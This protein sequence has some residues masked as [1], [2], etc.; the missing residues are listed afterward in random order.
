MTSAGD[1]FKGK[2]CAGTQICADAGEA[3]HRGSGNT[4]AILYAYEK[5]P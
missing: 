4:L 5:F 2:L 1:L 3:I